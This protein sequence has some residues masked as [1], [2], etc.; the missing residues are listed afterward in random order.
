MTPTLYEQ[1]W[2]V[3]HPT[4]IYGFSSLSEKIKGFLV[5]VHFLAIACI[6]R[7]RLVH[8]TGSN[9]FPDKHQ[10]QIPRWRQ[11]WNLY[12]SF[13]LQNMLPFW[14]RSI[15]CKNPSLLASRSALTTAS[16]H[17][18]WL[19]GSSP[20]TT[21]KRLLSACLGVLQPLLRWMKCSSYVSWDKDGLHAEST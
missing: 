7:K 3:L 10:R 6:L 21:C 19:L 9:I 8:V 4:R 5:A 2:A 11:L 13:V 16:K 17:S 18:S 20:A 15:T 14:R 12:R 1:Q